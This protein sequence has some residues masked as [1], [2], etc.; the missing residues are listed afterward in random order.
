M[1]ATVSTE[2]VKQR[3][4][5][6]VAFSNTA[7]RT[8]RKTHVWTCDYDK[9]YTV[10]SYKQTV[11]LCRVARWEKTPSFQAVVCAKLLHVNMNGK[12]S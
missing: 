2:V 4:P 10:S 9:V 5:L 12:W 8:Y 6:A 11:H 1:N 7:S 3:P